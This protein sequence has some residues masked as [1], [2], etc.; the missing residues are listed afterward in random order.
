[1]TTVRA[2][3]GA[4]SM[5]A[6]MGFVVSVPLAWTI[7]LGIAATSSEKIVQGPPYQQHDELVQKKMPTRPTYE[8]TTYKIVAQE[9]YPV[10]SYIQ[11]PRSA[12]PAL[13]RGL[14]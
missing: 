4:Y 11:V 13:K 5:V 12:G 6:F 9:K 3:V 1:M 14:E 2:L 10:R 8:Q 7:V